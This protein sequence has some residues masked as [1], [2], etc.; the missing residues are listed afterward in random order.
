MIDDR[1]TDALGFIRRRVGIPGLVTSERLD[2]LIM[3]SWMQ[4]LRGDLGESETA[5][6]AVREGLAPGQAPSWVMGASG[7]RTEALWTL[8][9]W[10]EALVEAA[11]CEQAWRESQIHAPGFATNAFLAAF[12]ISRARRD[13]VDEEH[14]RGVAETIIQRN[15][16]T[17]RN[18]R[19]EAFYRD[20][21]PALHETV[22]R[23]HRIF[24]GR[25]DYVHRALARLVDRRHLVEEEVLT[26]LLDYVSV[27]DLRFLEAHTRRA[28]GVLHHR[29]EFLREALTGFEAMHARPFIARV[30]TE[31]GMLERDQAVVDEGLAELERMGDLD[32]MERAISESHGT[33]R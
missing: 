6:A 20:D 30:K 17:S 31:L 26:E 28:I 27:R 25:L 13:P 12:S 2:A 5:A 11:R 23:H 1:P 3:L 29:P 32:Q 15:G 7:W 19:M 33:R 8:G 14:W 16:P 9:R 18:R 22:V 21:L 24:S 10:D 4:L